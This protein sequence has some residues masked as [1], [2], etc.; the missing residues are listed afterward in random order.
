MMENITNVNT[1]LN[2]SQTNFNLLEWFKM[3]MKKRLLEIEEMHYI[4]NNTNIQLGR[5]IHYNKYRIIS[6]IFYII[7]SNIDDIMESIK[8]D[9]VVRGSMTKF[10]I[11]T[12]KKIEQ[13]KVAILNHPFSA[14]SKEEKKIIKICFDEMDIADT[15]CKKYYLRR[16]K[17]LLAKLVPVCYKEEEDE[18][19]VKKVKKEKLNTHIR[20]D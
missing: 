14:K 17:R 1:Y 2:K 11:A 16:S 18:D 15:I 6:E 13:L 4:I 7:H 9:D 19:D 8:L 20:F 12:C 10:I 5:R 3:Y